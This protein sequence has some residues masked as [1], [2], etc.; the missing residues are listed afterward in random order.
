MWMRTLQGFCTALIALLSL[1]GCGGGGG[2]SSG[3][4][5][6]SGSSDDTSISV[7]PTSVSFNI[8]EGDTPPA[9]TIVHIN[10]VGDGV[11]VGYAPGVSQPSWLSVVQV[12]TATQTGV[13][14]GLAVS[15]TTTVGSRST[16][17]R[18][19]T[20]RKD[21]TAVKTFDL[22]VTY[23]ITASNLAISTSTASLSFSAIAGGAVPAPQPVDVAY[24]GAIVSVSG[25]PAWL[26]VTP[27]NSGTSPTTYA[28][29]VNS[30][31]F[32][33]GTALSADVTFSTSKPGSTLQRTSTVHVNYLVVQPFAATASAST[34]AFTSIAKSTQAAQPSAGYT[35]TIAGGQARW[36]V[37]SASPWLKFT[38]ASGSGAGSAVVTA[39]SSAQGHG[40]FTGT[41]TVT[42]DD[43]G[44][45]RSFQ[46][47]LNDRAPR[48]VVAPSSVAFTVNTTT[49]L[50]GLTQ[51]VLVTDELN[52]AA[53]SEA[54]SW[55]LITVD[56]QWLQWAP[57]GGTSSPSANS[58]V[59][60]KTTELDKLLPGHYTATITL[61]SQSADGTGATLAI[62][63]TL[64]YKMA[65]VTFV[66]SY[67]GV[68]NLPGSMYVRGS[69]FRVSGRTV[70]VSIGST[71][72]SGLTPD[73]DTQIRVSYPALAAGRY[74]VS[75]KNQLGILATN[76][77]LVVLSPPPLAYQAITAPSVRQRLVYDDERN[78]LYGVN[79]PDQEIEI[80]T[81][82]NGTLSAASPYVLPNV[83][84]IAL[85]PNG[86]SLIVLTQQEV[87]EISLTSGTFVA[88]PRTPNPDSGCGGFL[89]TLAMANDGKAF[90]I[91][92]LYGCSGYTPSYLYNV[93]SY[94]LVGNVG[95]LYDGIVAGAADGSKLFAGTKNISPPQP[96]ETFNALDDSVINDANVTY[97][98]TAAT[99]SGNASR[100]IL[101]GVDVYSGSMTLLG[102]LPSTA[103]VVLASRDSSRAYVYRDDGSVPRLDIYNLNGALGA[104]ALYPLL[105]TVNLTDSPNSASLNYLS[106]SLAET[107]D[108][109]T[110]FVSGDSRI[111][112]QPVN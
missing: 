54:V 89:D 92:N 100:V 99:V 22:P 81:L 69:N 19:V 85:T 107:L 53:G 72:I 86:R 71:N 109:N 112:V 101:Q 111:V 59:S 18:F 1:A 21:G 90:V 73:G 106:I 95:E 66:G 24:N 48:L 35:L 36:R 4:G 11:V 55:S 17:V 60:L 94:A 58:T 68:A 93:T 64:D 23:T 46:A 26:T 41:V 40:T 105:K 30:T 2:D 82:S 42:D 37:T 98:L 33:G 104:G 15:D 38:P 43:S 45:T 83:T 8:T 61:S 103:G 28:F 87:N 88:Q 65:Y 12:G 44:A 7:A 25:V 91:S 56:A 10:F 77:E 74:P 14:F 70:T 47:T 31:A 67:V 97:N 29:A 78:T 102:H 39:D 13:D 3:G 51:T 27:G 110:V 16:S 62:P 80:Y 76:A 79:L 9:A 6:G 96:V 52:G 50:S 5:G 32:T 20:G 84:D 108:G 34:L 75:I 49:P 57:A 63:V